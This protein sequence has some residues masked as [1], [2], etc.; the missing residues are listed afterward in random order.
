MKTTTHIGALALTL[1]LL[2]GL[3]PQAGAADVTLTANAWLNANGQLTNTTQG[4]LATATSGTG[5]QADPYIFDV[6]GNL[7]MGSYTILGNTANTTYNQYSATWRVTGSVT[8]TG[9]FDSYTSVNGYYGGNVRIEAGGTIALNRVNARANLNQNAGSIYLWAT[10]TVTVATYIDTR[11]GGSGAAGAVTIRSEGPVSG[12][13]ITISGSVNGYD[14]N[15]YSI[16]TEARI[17]G[18]SATS[19][20]AVS[21]YC[22]TNIT[23]AAG[24]STRYGTAGAVLIRGDVTDG[25]ARAGTVSIGGAGGLRTDSGGRGGNVTVRATAFQ[26]TG[27][28]NT[29]AAVYQNRTGNVDID[30]LENATIGGFIDTRMMYRDF[31]HGSPGYV[32]IVARRIALLGVDAGGYSVRTWPGTLY[33]GRDNTHSSVAGDADVTLTGIDT[34]AEIY[35]PANPTNSMTSSIY[36]AGKIGTGRWYSDNAMGNVR[37]AAVEVQLVGDVTNSSSAASSIMSIRYGTN[38]YGVVTHLVENGVR[39]NGV[40]SH[41]ITYFMASGTNTFAG[42]VPYVGKL[43]VPV[44]ATIENR[45]ATN[46]TTT[47]A[48]FR[49]YLSSVGSPT[50]AVSVIWGQTPGV[51]SNTNSWNAGDWGD[52][53]YPTTN[54]TL[55]ADGNYYYTFVAANAGGTN[56]ATPAQYLITGPLTPVAGDG[57]CGVSATDTASI[58]ISRPGTCV[59][60]P[61]TVNYALSGTGTGYVSA[62]PASGFTLAAGQQSTNV[63]F[64]PVKP[65]VGAPLGVTLTLLP[66]AYPGDALASDSITVAT[67]V[68]SDVT[69]TNDVYIDA[70]DG[71][72]LKYVSGGG[73]VAVPWP[74]ATLDGETYAYTYQ[75]NNLTLGGYNIHGALNHSQSQAS[76]LFQAGGH[77]SG[78]GSF[79]FHTTAGN[80]IAGNLRLE[81]AGSIA[82]SNVW[83]YLTAPNGTAASTYLWAKG[84]P[85]TLT[86]SINNEG[87]STRVAPVVVRSEGPVGSRGIAIAGGNSGYS[88]RTHNGGSSSG[89]KAVWLCTEGDITL[90]GD[91]VATAS[92]GGVTIRGNYTNAAIRAGGVVVHGSIPT[93]VTTGNNI[94]YGSGNIA[95]L[96]TNLVVDGNFLTYC[97]SI[98]QRGGGIR[99]DVTGEARFGGYLDTHT[100]SDGYGRSSPG[101]V[102]ILARRT[103]INGTNTTGHSILTKPT[104]TSGSFWASQPGDGNIT[105]TNVD[106]STSGYNPERPLQSDTSSLSVSGKVEAAYCGVPN[107]Q[108]DIYLSA[109]E[110]QLSGEIATSAGQNSDIAVHYGVTTHGIVT[111]LVENGVRWNGSGGHN[112]IYGVATPVF[113]ADVPYKGLWHPAGTVLVVY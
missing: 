27:G 73:V 13:G 12:Q 2:V 43:D 80:L 39:W 15:A 78:G 37:I 87:A 71:G 70:A 31:P 42:D 5:T 47:S 98:Y 10:G 69:L 112:V 21:L 32:K 41:N 67:V 50:S 29:S 83:T 57:L 62:S 44:P 18:F 40:A 108:G 92:G 20:G 24:L 86:G 17:G 79:Q 49:G 25:T 97:G 14:G 95:V 63:V 96:A 53:T 45:P 102:F 76:A 64:T 85:V 19:G 22:Q 82:L 65:N 90:G 66:G 77:V 33:A 26:L 52:Y 35:D 104:A 105:L 60:G 1:A 16:L 109:V 100:E 7:N 91:V 3:T 75:F 4:V 99:V 30:V 113:Y 11:T 72:K 36:V 81:A 48:T 8:D 88:I 74:G 68:A 106:T 101:P 110:V 23:L 61:L 38:A 103:A 6:S 84:G 111:H 59:S 58:A 51:Y 94:G 107:I 54:L 55:A 93:W 89:G 46:I 34:S 9:N 56:A 28:I